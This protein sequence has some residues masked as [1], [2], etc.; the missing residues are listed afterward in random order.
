MAP[1]DAAGMM[2]QPKRIDVGA[3]EPE[4]WAAP[5]REPAAAGSAPET[6]GV[7]ERVA[8]GAYDD[9]WYPA[10]RTIRAW[11]RRRRPEAVA[12]VAFFAFLFVLAVRD[13]STDPAWSVASY[14]IAVG[15]VVGA[16]VAAWAWNPVPLVISGG[17]LSYPRRRGFR[18]GSARL[19]GFHSFYWLEIKTRSY[20]DPLGLEGMRPRT[21]RVPGGSYPSSEL[22]RTVYRYLWLQPHRG[23]AI[24]L[25][26]RSIAS[27]EH[28]V[29]ALRVNGLVEIGKRYR[30][31]GR[32]DGAV[33][34]DA[35][36]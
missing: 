29:H 14:A 33:Y 9:R 36:R 20:S 1:R 35:D 4:A 34:Y 17:I 25:R 23:E 8:A 13:W 5:A 19:S 31:S 3:E 6:E 30:V 2:G 28:L 16:V 24:A 22:G 12:L 32:N 27:P 18:A 21:T 11:Y 10:Y 15:L 7:P 26:G